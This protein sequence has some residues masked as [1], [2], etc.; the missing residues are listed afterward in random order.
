M[1][2][3]LE[4]RGDSFADITPKNM[5]ILDIVVYRDTL[6]CFDLCTDE[7]GSIAWL[8]DSIVEAYLR[9]LWVKSERLETLGLTAFTGEC[10][11]FA[12]PLT[13]THFECFTA[14]F[15]DNDV[16]R[17]DLVIFPVCTLLHF[18]LLV[19]LKKTKTL[20]YL[21]SMYNRLTPDYVPTVVRDFYRLYSAS[22]SL[23]GEPFELVEWKT[24]YP[25]DLPQQSL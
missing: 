6:K 3:R 8:N 12:V 10:Y 7:Y 4:Y 22:C 20:L 21:N 14:Y 18:T 19:C 1:K 24:H 5:K 9:I 23:A 16:V 2:N 11:I 13:R 17:K 15:V 25:S